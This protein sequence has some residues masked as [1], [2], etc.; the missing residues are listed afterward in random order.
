MS[1]NNRWKKAGKTGVFCEST[2]TECDTNKLT[3]EALSNRKSTPS[4]VSP[5]K[6]WTKAASDICELLSKFHR[7]VRHHTYC[8]FKIA[9]IKSQREL[10]A[11]VLEEDSCKEIENIRSHQKPKGDKCEIIETDT[12]PWKYWG[13]NA[14]HQ[15]SV[16]TN[17]ESKRKYDWSFNGIIEQ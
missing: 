1:N 4:P 17:E 6:V 11:W 13:S 8:L 14:Q 10:D 16:Q 5:V 7:H 12:V 2:S 3:G 9:V 15:E